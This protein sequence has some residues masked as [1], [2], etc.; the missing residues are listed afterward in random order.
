MAN[1]VP[2]INFADKGREAIEF[3][4]GVFGGDADVQLVKDS[5]AAAQMPA[6][7]GDRILHLD[8]RSG[9][10]NF[11][12]SDIISDQ[13]GRVVG[14]VY[15][16]AVNCDSE[17]QLRAYHASLSE[18]ATATVPVNTAPWGDLYGECT[19]KYGIRWMLNFKKS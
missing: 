19:D 5:P 12:G 4:K 13:A 1:I 2:Y 3:Y 15:S 9:D 17:E 10:I 6:E 16:L 8:F 14:N 18:G 7:W 11:L